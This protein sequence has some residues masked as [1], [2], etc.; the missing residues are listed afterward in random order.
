MELQRGLDSLTICF[1]VLMGYHTVTYGR[2][3]ISRESV[4]R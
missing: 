3:D 2:T 1:S 4:A